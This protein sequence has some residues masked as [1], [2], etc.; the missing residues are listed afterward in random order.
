M[1][2][3]YTLIFTI[4]CLPVLSAPYHGQIQRFFQPDGSQVD[5]KLFGDERYMRAEG[6]DGY[7]L[8]REGRNGWICYAKINSEKSELISTGRKYHGIKDKPDSWKQWTDL[9][10]HLDLPEKEI[11][12]ISKENSRLLSIDGFHP[13]NQEPTTVSGTPI[14]PVEGAIVGLCVLID[15][16]DEPATLPASEYHSF[17]N[18]LN[19]N[20]F[21]NNGS[22]RS[23]FSDVSRGKVD[24]TNTITGFFRAPRTFAYYDSLPYAQGARIIL[25]M[26]LDSLESQGF[27]FSTL[28]LNEDNTIMAINLMYTG[29]PPVWAQGMW[30]HKGYINT[31]ES[32]SG[33]R[34][35]DYNCSPAN[36]PLGIGVVVHENGHMIGKW[37]DTYKYNS[38]N[39]PDGI[40][41]FDLMCWYGDAQNPVPPN[42]L[43]RMNAGWTTVDTVTNFVGLISDTSNAGTIRLYENLND[44][45]EFYLLEARR[46]VGRSQYIPDQGLTVWRINRNGD[47]QTTNHEVKLIPA[48]NNNSS[49][50]NACFKSGFYPQ[51]TATTNPNS[52]WGN[53]DPSGLRITAISQPGPVMSYQ[54]GPTGTGAILK[55]FYQGL[56]EDQNGDGFIE[57]GEW[58]RVRVKVKNTGLASSG[59]LVA[60]CVGVSPFTNYYT[61]QDSPQNFSPLTTLSEQNIEFQIQILPTAVV[62]REITLRFQVSE[63]GQTIYVTRKLLLGKYI[64]MVHGTDSLC[65]YMFFD[66]SGQFRY[67]N[68]TN[69]TMT[70]FPK[71]PNSKVRVEFSEFDLE[72]SGNCIYDHLKIYNGPSRQSSLLGTW[73]GTNSP[74]TLNSTHSSGALTFWFKADEGVTGEGWRAL[75]S[76][77]INTNK[78][79]NQI[80][81]EWQPYPNPS[82]GI[83]ILPAQEMDYEVE[84]SG[85][86]GKSWKNGIIQANREEEIN[87]SFL[88]A[89][90]YVLRAIHQNQ[91]NSVHRLILLK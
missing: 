42:P 51:F 46:A 1:R 47:N 33:I 45:V 12:S 38:N 4:F 62:G 79:E 50:N 54:L 25:K 20:N 67:D 5:V 74:G 53:T 84:I 26:A 48:N 7:T 40:G 32:I 10:K 56:I 31:F 30:H 2:F 28:T 9:Q 80:S 65:Q 52:H 82:S 55:L 90:V 91:K 83:I 43:F 36:A 58:I 87:L 19:Y 24:Y 16:A 73:C 63:T 89:G 76:C 72:A 13:H 6:M 59:N 49:Q 57:P 86:D 37:P 78:K 27:D 14:H 41:A 60:T 15:F 3:L 39:G 70:I 85:L 8:V 22:L 88:P 35:G 34:A 81:T 17:C 64:N 75:I 29:V 18:D 71:Q 61:I 66:P 21:N 23:Y 69:L 68:N 77:I 44:S 11:K